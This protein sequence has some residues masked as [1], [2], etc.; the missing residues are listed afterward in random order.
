MDAWL[1][2]TIVLSFLMSF[3]IGSNDASNGLATSYGSKALGL[4]KLIVLGAIAEF[5][6]AM[7][8]SKDVAATLSDKIIKD[9]N[10]IEFEVKQRMMFSIVI[11]SF[12]F[13]I[14]SSGFGMP[15]SGT[16][17]VIGAYM[18]AGIIATRNVDQ[19]NWMKLVSIVASWFISPTL[20]ALVAFLLMLYVSK[21]ILD[22]K[23]RSFTSRLHYVQIISGLC[24]SIISVVM[25]ELLEFAEIKE[26]D[27]IW[28][29]LLIDGV[30]FAAAF[31]VGVVIVRLLILILFRNYAEIKM[32]GNSLCR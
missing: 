17:T 10:D 18:G 29:I 23:T 27:P 8:C 12:A 15:I 25:V 7:F 16:H 9:F 31:P 1:I 4:Y 14:C 28:K 24:F 21:F 26:E 22:T 20:S 2:S 13:I 5:V 30:V 3:S 6:G 11:A 19:I 32:G